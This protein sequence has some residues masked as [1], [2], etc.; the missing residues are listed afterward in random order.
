MLADDL[1]AI[2]NAGAYGAVMASFYN[3]RPFVPEVL[4]EGGRFRVV[5]PRIDALQQIAFDS[6]G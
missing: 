6:A 4:V 1:V 2:R 3:T 5:R